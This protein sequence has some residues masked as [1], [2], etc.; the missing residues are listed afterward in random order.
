MLGSDV[1]EGFWLVA[2]ALSS[3]SAYLGS[4]KIS[5]ARGVPSGMAQAGRPLMSS[6]RT[7]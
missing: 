2:R 4:R 5:L 6:G 1:E 7:V 3:A